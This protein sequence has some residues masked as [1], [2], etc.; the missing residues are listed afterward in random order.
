[1]AVPETEPKLY[2]PDSQ[3]GSSYGNDGGTNKSVSP[4]ELVDQ[5]SAATHYSPS[6]G[7]DNLNYSEGEDKPVSN[8][9]K[10]GVIKSK[11]RR[12]LLIAGFGGGGGAVLIILLLLLLAGFL[13]VPG[14]EAYIVQ[15]EF[16]R[17]NREFA[18]SADEVD[19]AKLSIDASDSGR[20]AQ[21]Q[22][23]Y[24]S[25]RDNT[26]GKLD[27][28]R[29]SI[30]M[31]NLERDSGLK[32]NYDGFTKFGTPILSSVSLDGEEFA[33][34]QQTL[35]TKFIPVVKQIID[36]KNQVKFANDFAPALEN[37]M[38][39]DGVGPIIRSV[40]ANNVR[41]ELGI[42]LIAWTLGKFQGKTPAEAEEELAQQSYVDETATGT[43]QPPTEDVSDLQNAENA[44]K[45]ATNGDVANPPALA[46]IIADNG[47]DPTAINTIDNVVS[48]DIFNNILK[49]IASALNP[50]YTIALPACIVYEGSL[51]QAGPTINNQTQAQEKAFYFLADAG[52][53][54]KAGGPTDS[55]GTAEATAVGAMNAKLGDV[56]QST[57]YIWA[58]GGTVDTSSSSMSAEA[59]PSGEYTLLDATLPGPIADVIGAFADN[60][61]PALTNVWF[62]IG[63]GALAFIAS[64]FVGESDEAAARVASAEGTQAVDDVANSAA[65]NI[66]DRLVN[67]FISK[68]GPTAVGG[69]GGYVAK[70][71]ALFGFNNLASL[72]KNVAA[73]SGL[74]ILSKIIV[75]ERA[76]GL[77]NGL[78]ENADYANEADS[79]ANIQAG[80][81]ER[82]QLF[83]RPLTCSEID[84]SDQADQQFIADQNQS[85]SFTDRYLALSN[86]NSLLFHIASVVY[87]DT[88]GSILN[89]VSSLFSNI[90][91]GPL[92]F[93]SLLD[94]LTGVARA[95]SSCANEY[96]GNVQ[97]GWSQAEENLI[98]SNNGD[99]SYA[100]LENQATLDAAKDSSGNSLENDIAQQYAYC[101]GYDY[102]PNGDSLD[103]TDPDS[104]LVSDITG[105]GPYLQS[106]KDGSLG[107]LLSNGD[108][109]RDSGGDV[110]AN[111]GNCSPQN[112][113]IDNPQYGDLVFRWR[114]AMRYDTSINQLTS[115][116]NV[117]N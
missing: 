58:N 65:T 76:G 1:M 46:G 111:Q 18:D 66:V 31:Q 6:S 33:V 57:P 62:A 64:L 21:L 92:G 43:T 73:I 35:K 71:R 61:C 41:K 47:V 9:R 14:L 5:E 15:R 83:G 12:R 8:N 97:F 77:Y 95:D 11:H 49:G 103:P 82:Q 16:T 56:S 85:N 112:L 53:E 99:N 3:Q 19:E 45:D 7:D 60:A 37:A 30:V 116:Q 89:P 81:L 59:S 79:G 10:V 93:G 32:L 48:N 88:N 108:I 113:G 63:T 91:S 26:W 27:N 40:V 4:T 90:V 42:G 55:T 38:D 102:N 23:A 104:N 117:T 68:Y 50:S 115:M 98:N 101:F 100:P 78:E 110:I 109:V 114:L 70:V 28:Y 72:A 67:N 52:D 20:L 34:E 22:S 107:G 75:M 17:I 94:N 24:Q 29:P 105:N 69:F 44:A 96:Y 39:A 106:N 80:E 87:T 86:P 74:T 51:D 36:F 54:Q 13:K 25:L 84:Q 2:D